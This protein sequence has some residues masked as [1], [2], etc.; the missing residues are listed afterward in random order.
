MCKFFLLGR[1][2][3]HS[4]TLQIFPTVFPADWKMYLAKPDINQVVF[5]T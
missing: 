4:P 5:L 2:K 1:E 3:Y